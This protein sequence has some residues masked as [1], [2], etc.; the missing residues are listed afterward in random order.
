MI[1]MITH[2]ISVVVLI[3]DDIAKSTA[4][5]SDLFDLKP[6]EK[7][8]SYAWFAFQN[9]ELALKTRAAAEP[10]VTAEA[11][12]TEICFS[13]EDVDA[14]YD[15]WQKKGL[16]IAQTPTEMNFGRAFTALDPDG[17]RIR[18]YNVRKK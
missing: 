8:A 10:K 4:F 18:V 7:Y 17:H 15:L 9:I 16:K 2:K 5:Y 13:V 3:V 6:S 12:A 1:F 11:G 14:V